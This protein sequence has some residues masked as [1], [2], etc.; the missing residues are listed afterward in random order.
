M[1]RFL[2]IKGHN[3]LFVCWFVFYY[4]TGTS[5]LRFPLLAQS[6]PPGSIS[7]RATWLFLRSY[8]RYVIQPVSRVPGLGQITWRIVLT[9]NMR[10]HLGKKM[11][12]NREI[13]G[14]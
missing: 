12:R 14:E 7:T 5:L 10:G 3:C 13:A 11:H 1:V 6:N 9:K 8:H 2:E 4:R